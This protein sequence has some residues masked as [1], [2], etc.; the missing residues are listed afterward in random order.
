MTHIVF[1]SEKFE[2]SVDQPTLCLCFLQSSPTTTPWSTFQVKKQREVMNR[3]LLLYNAGK[4]LVE[5][6]S[7][8]QEEGGEA[9]SIVDDGELTSVTDLPPIFATQIED[10]S[11]SISAKSSTTKLSSTRTNTTRGTKKTASST[12]V[13]RAKEDKKSVNNRNF[14]ARYIVPTEL[15]DP[16]ILLLFT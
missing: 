7:Q 12:G 10:D 9:V 1:Y 6:P 5:P 15:D 16:A 11:V 3:Q 8:Q 13:R 4:D 14:I 2:D